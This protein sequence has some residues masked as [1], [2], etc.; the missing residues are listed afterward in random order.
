MFMCQE[1]QMFC[2]CSRCIKESNIVSD[3][4][5]ILLSFYSINATLEIDW[6]VILSM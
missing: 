1:L 5:I 6:I 2:Y 4:L 3:K